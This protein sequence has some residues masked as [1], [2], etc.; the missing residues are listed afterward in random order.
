MTEQFV[1]GVVGAPFGVKGF[2][3]VKPLSGES[4]HL[5][6]LKS[7]T[8]RQGGATRTLA[9]AESA[10]AAPAVIMRFAGFDSPEAA[11]ALTGAEIIVSREDAAPLGPGEFYVEDLKGVEVFS[12]EGEALGKIVAVIEGGGGDLA[13]LR[14]ADGSSRLV[15]FRDEFFAEVD[16]EKGRATLLCPWVLE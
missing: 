13:E 14:L 3:K 9:V 6:R 5:L 1:A 4:A 7:V 15:P 10:E 12:A 2:V 8:L 11:R 16:A